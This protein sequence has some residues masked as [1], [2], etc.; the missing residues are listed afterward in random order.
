MKPFL[1]STFLLETKTAEN[2]YHDYAAEQ[3]IYD[4]HCHLSPQLIAEDKCF[5]NLGEI[6][7]DGDH[8]K[9]RAMRCNGVDEAFISGKA[10][11]RAKFQKWAETVPY[12]LRNPLY[13][14]TH[15]EL[16]RYFGVTEL[17]N[18]ESAEC[19]YEQ[20]SERLQTPEYSV[21]NLMRKMKVRTACTTDDPIDTLEAHRQLA[22]EGFEIRV[23]PSFRPDRAMNLSN[24]QAWKAYIHLLEKASNTAISDFASLLRAI[25]QRHTYFHQMGCRLA[26][27]GLTLIRPA[28]FTR[29]QI[30]AIFSKAMQG[31][32]VT[33]HEQRQFEMA[34]LNEVCRLHHRR[35]WVQQ[36]HIGA[37]RNTNTRMFSTLGA[38]A[39]YDSIADYQQGPGVLH[40]LDKLNKDD[41]LGKT[42]LYNLNPADNATFATM[43]GNFQDGQTVGKIQWGAAWWFLDQKDGI[44]AHLNAL[45]RL[46]LLSRFAGM[47]T[48]SRSFLSYPRHEYF[49]RILCNLIGK[50]VE[51]GEIPNDEALLKPFIEGIC[52]G[53]AKNYFG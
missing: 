26:D 15:L 18:A 51:N 5:D 31:E 1:D 36:F 22:E 27:H 49:R 11:W 37:F 20:C 24:P 46:G 9:W 17:L 33:E 23:K 8:Y 44:E 3:P 12:T 13:H 7:L 21:R 50:D 25:E 43:A 30:E 39:G 19:I 34:F 40:L 47:L 42:I 28:L 6:W 52:Y 35:G 41:E 14:W 32:T 45:S 16:Q 38:D 29:G 10:P 48:D 4:Y 53:N 2:L